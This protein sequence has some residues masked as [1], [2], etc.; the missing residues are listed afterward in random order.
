M[1]GKGISGLAV[2]EIAAGLI[3][4]WSGVE[5]IPISATVGSLV[6]GKAPP[7]GPAQQLASPAPAATG[8]PLSSAQQNA[9][10]P[11]PPSSAT[12]AAYKAFAMSLLALHGWPGQ[13]SSFSAIVGEE[14]ASWNPE[15]RNPTSGALG[16]AQALGHGQGAATAAAD[17]TNE[18]GNYGTPDPVC[19]LANGGQGNAQ[20][21]WMCNYIAQAY[22]TPDAAQAFHLANGYY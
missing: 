22:K 4:A 19:K 11:N 12:V 9:I 6:R 16:I 2:T 18:Y 15:T 5:N 21:I 10:N 14:D 1:A 13:W 7:K 17:G 20:L 3:L 8:S